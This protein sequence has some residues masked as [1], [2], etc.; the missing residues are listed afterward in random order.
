MKRAAAKKTTTTVD[1]DLQRLMDAQVARSQFVGATINLSWRLALTVI[2]PV[3]IG[4]KLDDKFNT[5]PSF[6]LTS[7]MLATVG[8]CVAIW[9]TVKE[10]NQLQADEDKKKVRRSKRAK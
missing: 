5:S 7:L 9:S 6:V 2:I 4:V 10:I 8:A 1:D 3:L